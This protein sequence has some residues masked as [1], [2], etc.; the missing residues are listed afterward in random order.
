MPD[1]P[2]MLRELCVAERSYRAVSKIA[3]GVDRGRALLCIS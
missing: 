3:A 1:T 2:L